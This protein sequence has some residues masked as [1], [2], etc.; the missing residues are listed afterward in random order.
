MS[1]M[2]SACQLFTSPVTLR[3]AS[4]E[5]DQAFCAG[6]TLIE[7]TVRADPASPGNPWLEVPDGTRYEV[8]WPIGYS[9]RLADRVELVNSGGAVEAREGDVLRNLDVCPI[10]DRLLLV[11]SLK[12][13]P[14]NP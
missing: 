9:A 12:Q 4:P 10:Q 1:A 8:I 11:R 13:V 2:A 6:Y 5:Q 7:A 14:E 3:T